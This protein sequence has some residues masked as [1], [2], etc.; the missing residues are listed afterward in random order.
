MK[1]SANAVDSVEKVVTDLQVKPFKYEKQSE[2]LS[3]ELTKAHESL[4]GYVDVMNKKTA[5]ADAAKSKRHENLKAV[6]AELA[7]YLSEFKSELDPSTASYNTSKAHID[8]SRKERAEY[9]VA[10]RQ[11]SIRVDSLRTEKITSCVI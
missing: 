9:Y 4:A 8:K 10:K 7:S 1:D 5:P 6:R 3:T 11:L 2:Q